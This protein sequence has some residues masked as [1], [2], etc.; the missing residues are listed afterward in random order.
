VRQL[1]REQ[2]LSIRPLRGIAAR[3]KYDVI[4]DG[5]SV[6]AEFTRGFGSILVVMDAHTAEIEAK[7]WFEESPRGLFQ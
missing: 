1:V 5:V 2:A 7:A 6:C 4:R 3:A